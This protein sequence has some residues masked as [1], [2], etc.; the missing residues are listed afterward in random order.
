[1]PSGQSDPNL[2]NFSI[3]H[4]AA[5]IIPLL[6]QA[7]QRNPNLSGLAVDD[8]NGSTANGTLVQQWAQTNGHATTRALAKSRVKWHDSVGL[9][10]NLTLFVF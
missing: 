7:L 5:Y 1:L 4:D 10:S 2:N 8:T 9:D 3:S 6:Q